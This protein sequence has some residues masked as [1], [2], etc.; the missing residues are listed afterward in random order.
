MIN[1]LG[2]HLKKPFIKSKECLNTLVKYP[3]EELQ[4][5]LGG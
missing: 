3:K 2:F 5:K 1:N 4:L